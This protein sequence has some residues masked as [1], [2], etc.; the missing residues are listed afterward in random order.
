[1]LTMSFRDQFNMEIVYSLF[2]KK[3]QDGMNNKALIDVSHL[4]AIGKTTALVDFAKERRYAVIVPTRIE[5]ERLR[6]Y[7]NYEGVFSQGDIISYGRGMNIPC[8]IDE[9]VKLERLLTNKVNVKTG[10]TKLY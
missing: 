4:R 2:K 9:G 6:E 8:V 10:Y 1:M 3:L 5:A 7:F